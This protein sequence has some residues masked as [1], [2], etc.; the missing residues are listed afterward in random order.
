MALAASDARGS[1]NVAAVGAKTQALLSAGYSWTLF[2]RR[3]DWFACMA[4]SLLLFI[5]CA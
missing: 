5:V 1:E 3:G 4:I 2:Q